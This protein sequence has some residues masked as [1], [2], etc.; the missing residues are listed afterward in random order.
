MSNVV[1]V[2]AQ[3]GD[4]GKGRIVDWL[5]EKADIVARYNGGHNAG[6]TLVVDGRTYKLAL[7]PSGVVRGKLGVIGNGVALDPEA[8]LAEIGR[9]AALG[10]HVTPDVLR[11]AETATLVLPVH[12]AIDAAQERLRAKPLG[13]TLRGIGP[14][15]EDKVGRRGLRVCDLA[16][17]ELL[18]AKLDVLLEHHNA[19]LRGLGLEPFQREPML[20]DLLAM[21]PKIL[22][23]KARVWQL[24]D[25]AHSSG[26]RVVFEGS[27][28]V[29]LDV[30]WGSYPYVTSSSTIAAG[31][32]SGAGIAASKLGRVLGVSKVY[33]T[34]VGEG[35]FTSEV[36]GAL[37]DL[38][39]QRGGEYGVNTGRPRRC[40]W[41]DTVQ[42]RQSSKVAGIDL[43]ALTKLDVLDGFDS[44]YLCVGYELDGERI[45]YMPASDAEQQR[46]QPVLRRFDGWQRTT[47]GVRSYSE[48]PPQ[49]AALIEAIEQEVGIAVAMVTTGPERDDAIVLRPPFEDADGR[50]V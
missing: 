21:A 6:H 41:L 15:Y 31:A 9:M 27:Q 42:L 37:G 7:L 34:R 40:G 14:A 5:A 35:P 28:A 11:I 17:P 2:G 13:T 1:V 48:L 18:A 45:D 50:K 24:L 20:S 22:P 8:L 3:W 33:A 4:E 10:V 25:D 16:E 43:L 39:R 29:M 23:F 46:L 38:L 30:D 47:R 44:V 36:D 32:A 26:K 19:W 49:A 12:R